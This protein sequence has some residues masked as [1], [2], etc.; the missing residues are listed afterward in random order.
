MKKIK[1]TKIDDVT[2]LL[3]NWIYIGD[4][5]DEN[6]EC[7]CYEFLIYRDDEF[8]IWD[9]PISEYIE[10]DDQYSVLGV[11]KLNEYG[12]DVCVNY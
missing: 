1:F 10:L 6:H 12:A 3:N 2:E 7:S 11:A 9:E 4:V 5:Y 8:L